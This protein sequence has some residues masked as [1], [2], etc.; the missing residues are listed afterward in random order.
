[1]KMVKKFFNRVENTVGKGEIARCLGKGKNRLIYPLI[2]NQT[3]RLFAWSKLK[4]FADDKVK[5]AKTFFFFFDRFDNF[6]GKGDHAGN[7][8]VLFLHC[9]EVFSEGF[10]Y[11]VFKVPIAAN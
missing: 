8:Y 4:A 6:V 3:T 5:V 7:Q 10:F 1:M 11:G 2:R 9:F